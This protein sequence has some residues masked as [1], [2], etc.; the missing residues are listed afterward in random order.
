VNTV[1]IRSGPS[2]AFT[3]NSI[4]AGD[5]GQVLR[6]INKTGYN[7]TLSDLTGTAANQIDTFNGGG[8]TTTGDGAVTLIYDGTDSKWLLISTQ[9]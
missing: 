2:G 7:M 8:H 5:D 4:V 6:L 9:D 1:V 3:I